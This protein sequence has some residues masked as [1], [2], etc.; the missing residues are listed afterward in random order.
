V[1]KHFA[2]IKRG[3]T[4]LLSQGDV[5]PV[6]DE[7]A[8]MGWQVANQQEI[9]KSVLSDKSFMVKKL[10]KGR[11]RSFARSIAEIPDGYDRVDRMIRLPHGHTF[12]E[13]LISTTD[14]WKMIGYMTE[15]RG[16]H[17]LGEQV[18]HA[19]LGHDF[20]KV[21]GRIYT[22]DQFL[23]QLRLS[24]ERATGQTIPAP[25]P[26]KYH[27]KPLINVVRPD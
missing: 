21:T 2:S 17:V 11:G 24:Y 7:L 3:P 5:E 19:P 14:G 8:K 10:R 9:V 23:N 18:Q 25:P 26:R 4:E 15:T 13:G 27:P 6:F 22:S 20:N 1:N 12:L 16:G